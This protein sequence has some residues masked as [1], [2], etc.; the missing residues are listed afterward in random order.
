MYPAFSA[1]EWEEWK[2]IIVVKRTRYIGSI[3]NFSAESHLPQETSYF[4]SS[5]PVTTAAKTFNVGIRSH[6]SIENSLHYVKDVTLKEDASR[7]RTKQAPENVSLLKDMAL[8]IFRKQGYA[9]IAQAIRLVCHN[10]PLLW[11]MISE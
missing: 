8:N 3:A 10:V 9:N 7:I 2:S 5:L 6:W 11:K 1:P 4:I